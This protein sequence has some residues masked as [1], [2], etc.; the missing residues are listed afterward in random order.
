MKRILK[1]A[2]ISAV[3]LT[4]ACRSE[5]TTTFTVTGQIENIE[6]DYLLLFFK[7]NLDGS[8]TTIAV[9]SLK[10]G[11]FEFSASQVIL[12]PDCFQSRPENRLLI[13]GFMP[14]VHADG[15]LWGRARKGRFSG[16]WVR[17]SM[18]SCPKRGCFGHG[19]SFF[20]L[21]SISVPL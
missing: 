5:K 1:L 8:T 18:E 6:G 12:N 11:C 15:A 4:A 21:A 2:L 14:E 13:C 7:S 20:C 17:F 9:D 19:C 3:L 16:T 10:N